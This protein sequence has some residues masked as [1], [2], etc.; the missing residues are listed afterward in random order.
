MNKTF[1]YKYFAK[2]KWAFVRAVRAWHPPSESLIRLWRKSGGVVPPR[3]S[4]Q[5]RLVTWGRQ[6]T[7]ILRNYSTALY[8]PINGHGS[9]VSDP[10]DFVNYYTILRQRSQLT[11]GMKN[12]LWLACSQI[13][14]ESNL[15]S[16]LKTVDKQTISVLH[17]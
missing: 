14:G 3:I 9:K 16:H 10:Q 2:C 15:I 1:P 5:I 17:L 7:L 11:T 4:N 6:Y 12:R 13:L 8:A